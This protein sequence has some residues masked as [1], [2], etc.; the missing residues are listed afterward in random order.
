MEL[1]HFL[2]L[3]CSSFHLTL[4][5]LLVILESENA[6]D[7]SVCSHLRY[8]TDNMHDRCPLQLLLWLF[9]LRNFVISPFF[10]TN[11]ANCTSLIV[12]CIIWWLIS[13]Y[14][15]FTLTEQLYLIQTTSKALFSHLIIVHYSKHSSQ[16]V[17]L[18]FVTVCVVCTHK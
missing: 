1:Y 4:E 10:F 17:Y 14:S 7:S 8:K 15:F 13:D 16:N 5:N 2:F 6:S 18:C 9:Y 11:W 3:F 12:S